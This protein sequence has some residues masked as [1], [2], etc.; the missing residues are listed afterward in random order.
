MAATTAGPRLFPPAAAG[1]I[2]SGEVRAGGAPPPPGLGLRVN[3][4][5]TRRRILLGTRAPPRF[6]RRS[7]GSVYGNLRSH[8]GN[9][10][11]AHRP[12]PAHFKQARR[13]FRKHPKPLR[14]QG[15]GHA[16]VPP[17]SR[18]RSSAIS[19]N[20]RDPASPESFLGWYPVGLFVSFRQFPGI[21][22]PERG[23]WI[24]CACLLFD[25]IENKAV[26][27]PNDWHPLVLKQ[28]PRLRVRSSVRS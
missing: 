22:K 19:G 18:P 10:S 7:F 20:T 8:S 11:H 9:S 17:R 13:G 23:A 4:G 2:R 3:S 16:P 24:T 26:S 1:N 21:F 15:T 14:V 28:L 25:Q 6:R 5:N 27:R 12:F